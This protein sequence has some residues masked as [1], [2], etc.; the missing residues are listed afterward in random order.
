M[1]TPVTPYQTEASK[2]EQVAEMFD[3]IAP[4][5]D[6][7]NRALSMGIDVLWRRKAVRMLRPYAPKHVV[8]IATG[9]ADFAIEARKLQPERITGID[10][11]KEM[12]LIGREKVEKKGL[13]NLIQLEIGDSEALRFEDNGID[14]ITI[15]FGVRNFEN[16][17]RGL[18]EIHRVLR[19]G[20]AVVILEPS[21]P[22]RF[23]L[24]QLFAFH[25]NVLT[26]LI[27]RMISGDTSAYTYLPESVKAFPN[28]KDFVDICKNVGFSTAKY[29]PLTLGICSL[30][31]LE[32]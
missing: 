30:Y 22:T 13:K 14:A 19:P 8:D 1:N 17:S 26:P 5:Y 12:I 4:K 6:L 2:K 29:V 7:L 20:G 9:T 32:K 16:L 23:P 31:L 15:G 25:F 10:I 28:G 3:N 21:F 24:K 27:G 11:S 18:E